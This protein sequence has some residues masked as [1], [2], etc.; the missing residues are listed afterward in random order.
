M[1]FDEG[2]YIIRGP[3]GSGKSTLLGIIAGIIKPS[4]GEV[5]VLGRDPFKDDGVKKLIGFVGHKT[6]LLEDLSGYENWN[7][8]GKF[9]EDLA[10]LM[11]IKGILNRPI[12]TYSRGERVKLSVCIEISRY[13]KVL[14]LDEPFSSLD[15]CSKKSLVEILNGING[16]VIITAHGTIPLKAKSEYYLKNENPIN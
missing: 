9:N 1:V 2:V 4:Q 10:D 5:K 3:N 6:F 7:F 12:R 14:L 16:T 15:E 11:G 13:P 8:F